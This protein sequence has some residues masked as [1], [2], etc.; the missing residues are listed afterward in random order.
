M[1]WRMYGLAY[2]K[3][4]SVMLERL[5]S[6]KKGEFDKAFE[7]EPKETTTTKSRMRR[8]L[9]AGNEIDS[10]LADLI[11]EKGPTLSPE[12]VVYTVPITLTRQSTG[13]SSGS[14]KYVHSHVPKPKSKYPKG[15]LSV[16]R[17]MFEMKSQ[18][19]NTSIE[20]TFISILNSCRFNVVV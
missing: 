1:L 2:P 17:C 20:F 19:T 4:T 9:S 5:I 8:K 14:E 7:V 6:V 10:H 12:H 16:H 11:D 13:D 3:D 18:T 15:N